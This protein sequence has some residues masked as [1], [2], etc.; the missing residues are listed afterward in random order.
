MRKSD[1]RLTTKGDPAKP[2]ILFLHGFLGAGSDWLPYTPQLEERYRCILADLP[3]HGESDIDREGN[4]ETFFIETVDR[5]AALLRE[6]TERPG[7]LVGYSMGGR[8][9]LALALR[10]PEL[11]RAVGVVSA[12]PGLKTPEERAARVKSDE[13]LARKIERDF[14]GF[15]DAWYRAPLFSTLKAHPLFGEIESARR[16][17]EPETLAMALRL[18]GT[19][20]QPS[21]WEALAESRL[22]M[23]FMA[24]QKDPKYV[25]I[26]R[27]MVNLH[28]LSSLELFGE[29]GHTLHIEE[30]EGF[31]RRLTDFFNRHT[32]R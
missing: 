3:G 23:L 32:D 4:P 29:C 2:W 25:E 20:R 7:L 5:L 9:G 1:L 12:S 17:G 21:Y 27:Q 22:P 26:G 18:L 13:G 16:K 24:G 14:E 30:R 8:I 10:H 31:L 11:F 15:L 28:P 6:Q 19:G